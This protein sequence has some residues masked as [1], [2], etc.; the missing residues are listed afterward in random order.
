MGEPPRREGFPAGFPDEARIF[1]EPE[2]REVAVELALLDDELSEAEALIKDKGWERAVGL[3]AIF[4]RGMVALRRDRDQANR[5]RLS[6]QRSSED[7]AA[8]LLQRLNDLETRF[9]VMKHTAFVALHDIA[10]LRAK[11]AAMSAELP[12][13]LDT[14]RYLR[15]REDELLSR[16]HEL[17]TALAQVTPPPALWAHSPHGGIVRRVLVRLAHGIR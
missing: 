2:R 9:A 8:F 1:L 15:A 17:E 3:H 12:A 14:N 10:P 5:E 7:R 11:T 4:A 13:L 16:I 6:D